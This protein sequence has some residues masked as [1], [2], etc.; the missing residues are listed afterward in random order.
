MKNWK[1][2]LIGVLAC[3][4]AFGMFGM[5]AC[6]DKGGNNGQSGG[7]ESGSDSELGD[8]GSSDE[9]GSGELQ[10]PEEDSEGLMF[11]LNYGGES[12]A[13]SG[14]GTC[15][16]VV[17]KIPAEY[18]GLPVTQIKEKA[19]E[20]RENLRGVILP[21]CLVSIGL[22][23]FQYCPLLELVQYGENTQLAGIGGSAFRNCPALRSF[24]V[25]E[26]LTSIGMSAFQGSGLTEFDTG[27]NLEF[28]QSYTFGSCKDLKSLTIGKNVTKIGEYAFS[29]CSALEELV[30]PVEVTEIHLDAFMNC[31][32]LKNLYYTGDA[33]AWSAIESYNNRFIDDAVTTVYYFS[34]DEQTGGNYWYYDGNGEIA[35]W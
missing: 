27:D 9:Q 24:A 22:A 15:T 31:S 8:S 35:V 10:I 21:D 12:Y 3:V 7:S 14:M 16:D 23:A 2:M 29:R 18:E 33:E 19:F 13:V 6:T 26:S 1:K 34:A 30:L 32:A 11:T 4:C 25:P 5:S 20:F 28:I 17:V